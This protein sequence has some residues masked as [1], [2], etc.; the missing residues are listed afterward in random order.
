VYVGAA[1]AAAVALLVLVFVAPRRF[2]ILTED[3]GTGSATSSG[4]ITE[5]PQN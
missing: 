4:G 5:A 2:P 3:A 1:V